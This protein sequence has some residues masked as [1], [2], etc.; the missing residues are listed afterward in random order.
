MAALFA[1][2]PLAALRQAGLASGGTPADDAALDAAFAAT[3]FML[4]AF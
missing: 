2:A 1:G 4:D 3:P